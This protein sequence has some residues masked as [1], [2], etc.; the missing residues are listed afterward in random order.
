MTGERHTDRH[1]NRLSER[2]ANR[3]GQREWA[4]V[5]GGQTETYK[6]KKRYLNC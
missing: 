4:R 6:E 3:Q 1:T 5:G 2:Q